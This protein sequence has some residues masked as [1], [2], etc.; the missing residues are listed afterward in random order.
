MQPPDRRRP[1]RGHQH[2]RHQAEDA[3]HQDHRGAERLRVCVPRGVADPDHVAADVA[4]QKIVEI[5]RDQERA[6]QRRKRH[7]DA[8]GLQQQVPAPHRA[9]RAGGEDDDGSEQPRYRR[10]PRVLPQLRDVD[11][12]EQDEEEDDADRK[13]D[14]QQDITARGGRCWLAWDIRRKGTDT[15]LS[16]RAKIIGTVRILMIAPEP[17]FEPRGTP[18]SE[19]HRIRALT[20]LGHSVDLVTYPFGQSVSMPGLRVFRSLR[21]PFRGR[22]QDWS[23]ARE[24]SARRAARG[25]R[26]SSSAVGPLRRDPLT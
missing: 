19:F 20:A 18:F 13:L 22:G 24:D 8:L 12:R 23:V 17:F 3:V 1:K 4:R 5:G 26:V 14:R 25:Q 2:E 16:F 11:A 6:E 9:R 10:Q 21:P 15:V 7:L